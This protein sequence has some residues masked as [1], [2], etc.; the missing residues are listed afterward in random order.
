MGSLSD[1]DN[2]S[3]SMNGVKTESSATNDAGTGATTPVEDAAIEAAAAKV[4]A[5][6]S[7]LANASV[8]GTN[9]STANSTS[10]HAERRVSAM[11]EEEFY[12]QTLQ[13]ELDEIIQAFYAAIGEEDMRLYQKHIESIMGQSVAENALHAV[14]PNSVVK[15]V[16]EEGGT[17]GTPAST[18]ATTSQVS[19][20]ESATSGAPDSSSGADVVTKAPDFTLEDQDGD[21]INLYDILE[22]QNKF[23][24]LQFYRGKWC[25]HCNA[26]IMKWSREIDKLNSR[27]A[28]LIAISPML[29]DGTQYLA[30][31]RSLQYSICSDIGNE[32]AKKFKI[33]MV[34]EDEFRNKF[35]EWGED[36]P[37]CTG[38]DTWTIPLPAT[39]VIDPT[40]TIIMSFVDNDPGVR[41][42]V[43]NIISAIPMAISSVPEDG[44]SEVI[45]TSV[46]N[47]TVTTSARSEKKRNKMVGKFLKNMR[48]F[49]QQRDP[50]FDD[51]RS[52]D[53]FDTNDSVSV[54][55]G[56][57]HKM[58]R[59]T[60]SS[61][62][63]STSKVRREELSR[64]SNSRV[65]STAG[66]D[67]DGSDNSKKRSF[68]ATFV[69]NVTKN[70]FGKKNQQPM[71]FL[72]EYLPK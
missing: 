24:I 64:R 47:G 16:D 14:K 1:N 40:G 44:E 48:P 57:F 10:F 61:A 50:E 72:G 67:I 39:Y 11:Y 8:T 70:V 59:K 49:S 68:S 66:N 41:A 37:A 20:T 63:A 53:T 25:P 32:V 9:G 69:K 42:E 43:D 5:A 56:P 54:V 34:V 26:T 19:Q 28:T 58:R 52:S 22:N 62:T 17:D 71:E 36:V 27:N 6:S 31:K 12:P 13:E 2:V 15:V 45:R 38:D 21:M 29:P 4:A 33:T 55:S 3:S 60:F 18:A 51:N 65:A 23:V 46:M 35:L 30:T 7:S